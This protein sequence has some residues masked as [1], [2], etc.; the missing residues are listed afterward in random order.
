[1][2]AHS[3]ADK[4]VVVIGGS[5]IDIAG[6]PAGDLIRANSNPGHVSFSSGGVARNVAE[7]LAR[8]GA[9]ATLLT[10]VGDDEFGRQLLAGCVAAG[11]DVSRA[12]TS[13]RYPT[14]VYLALLTRE[15]DLD[16]AV[17]DMDVVTELN[18]A[19]LS[20]HRHL[21]S[22]AELTVADTNLD[23]PALEALLD[24]ERCGP[25]VVDGVSAS[26]VVRLAG[27]LNRV[28]V[29]KLN[30]LEAEVLTG[31]GLS[32]V[33]SA[34][35]ALDQLLGEGV[36]K[37]YLTLGAGGMVWG[38]SGDG[39]PEERGEVTLP[40]MEVVNVNGAGDVCTAALAFSI[41]QEEG[42]EESARFAVAASVLALRSESTM[43]PQLNLS[44]VRE[45]MNEMGFV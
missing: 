23:K 26:K 18:A 45:T 43:P 22:E 32:D 4:N 28:D 12:H 11:V 38:G 13:K 7:A 16:A 6:K 19:Y 2:S 35:R 9:S 10:A 40:P 25:L 8:L 27:L 31:I 1:M 30:R 37:V 14:S 29:L 3:V 36:K 17:S 41:L 33:R 42:L 34:M 20:R 5:N 24:M 39:V 44:T 21:I 15:G